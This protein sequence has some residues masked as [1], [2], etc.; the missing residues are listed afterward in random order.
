MRLVKKFPDE[1]LFWKFYPPKVKHNVLSEE[2][3]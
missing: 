2:I 1:R 3:P